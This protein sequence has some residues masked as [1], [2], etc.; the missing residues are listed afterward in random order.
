MDWGRPWCWCILL[1]NTGE[2]EF[3]CALRVWMR[4]IGTDHL[5]ILCAGE[6]AQGVKAFA[7]QPHDW[8]SSPQNAHRS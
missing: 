7:I 8:S 2:A 3:A 6:M 4:S 1:G 5:D